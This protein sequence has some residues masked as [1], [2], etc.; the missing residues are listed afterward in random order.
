MDAQDPQGLIA[1]WQFHSSSSTLIAARVCVC[2]CALH[3]CVLE[4]LSVCSYSNCSLL[5]SCKRFKHEM[6]GASKADSFLIPAS[7]TANLLGVL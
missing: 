5:K 7:F 2:V 1:G 3:L 4:L 6:P